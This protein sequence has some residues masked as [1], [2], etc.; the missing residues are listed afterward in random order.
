MLGLLLRGLCI[1]PATVG[2]QALVASVQYLKGEDIEEDMETSE[3]DEDFDDD[4]DL[5]DTDWDWMVVDYQRRDF[6]EISLLH[7]LIY[8]SDLAFFIIIVYFWFF[9]FSRCY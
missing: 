2:H 3:E 5:Y 9:R 8:T 7:F 6:S 1:F 4:E